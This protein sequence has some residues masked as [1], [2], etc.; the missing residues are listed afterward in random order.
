MLEL[1]VS[2]GNLWYVSTP[3]L[4][5]TALTV[6]NSQHIPSTRSSCVVLE[7]QFFRAPRRDPDGSRTPP[8][9]RMAPDAHRRACRAGEA[10]DGKERSQSIQCA[11]LT[12]YPRHQEVDAVESQLKV[13]E[14]RQA[15]NEKDLAAF[16][17]REKTE[18]EIA[19]LELL[20]PFA[21]YNIVWVTWSGVKEQRTELRNEILELEAANK[22][23]QDSHA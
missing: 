23:F 2:V 7:A 21:Q 1:N 4:L 12:S 15:T 3:A 20:I 17:L 13:Q 8:S 5:A 18:G 16:K 19:V 10:R 22:P 9:L 14:A 11:L 6:V